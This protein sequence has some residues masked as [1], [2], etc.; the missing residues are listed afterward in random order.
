MTRL[1]PAGP[2]LVHPRGVWPKFSTT[3]RCVA[4]AKVVIR[5]PKRQSNPM[6]DFII[7]DV[8]VLSLQMGGRM[9]HGAD[10]VWVGS[11]HPLRALYRYKSSP[12]ES[13]GMRLSA[14]VQLKNV[15][16][17]INSCGSAF[18]KA[19]HSCGRDCTR[20]EQYQGRYPIILPRTKCTEGEELSCMEMENENQG[21][22]MHARG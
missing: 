3:I 7:D 13:R 14:A 1:A 9:R 17:S 11:T 22:C 8:L 2:K 15:S 4:A 19:I 6:V 16:Y 18:D 5:L 12:A 20:K 10:S 21:Q